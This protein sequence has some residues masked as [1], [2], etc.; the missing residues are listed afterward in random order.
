M[1]YS[2]YLIGLIALALTI[3][4][5]YYLSR[6]TSSCTGCHKKAHNHSHSERTLAIIK[7][8]AVAAGNATNIKIVAQHN[9]FTIVD[10]KELTIDKATAE[11]FYA[12]HHDKPFY[13]SL[14]SY[15]TSG[16]SIVM[17]LER[18]NAVS[19][20]RNLMGATDPKK[21]Q[22]GTIRQLYGTDIEH[23]AVHGSDSVENAHKEIKIFFPNC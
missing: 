23:N 22:P 2:V 11:K 8:D 6:S 7:P 3:G 1:K 16:P 10:Q 20:W 12:V 13:H 9:G 18:D 17:L 14:I 15:I 4:G 5:L 21:A 19:V